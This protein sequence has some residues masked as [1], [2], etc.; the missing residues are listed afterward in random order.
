[1]Y[2]G[3]IQKQNPTFIKKNF[4]I[5]TEHQHFP[6]MKLYSPFGIIKK[7][8]RFNGCTTGIPSQN[9]AKRDPHSFH[10]LNT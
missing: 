6:G 9:S 2:L 3:K 7:I 10:R 5:T 4:I 1:M 8:A